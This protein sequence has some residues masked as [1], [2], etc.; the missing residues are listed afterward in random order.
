M[1]IAHGQELRKGRH[2]VPGHCY[3]L[4]SVTYNR[5]PV[6]LDFVSARLCIQA[7]QYQHNIGR[8]DSHAYVI[9]PDH[10]H[11]LVTLREKG[12]LSAIMQSVKGF[13]SRAIAK[14]Y[15]SRQECRSYVGAVSRPRINDPVWQK[16]YHDHALRDDE[17]LRQVARYIVANPVRAG[18]VRRAIEY[19]HWD[20]EWY[21]PHL[22]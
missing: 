18:L 5:Q 4:T 1:H 22:L 13:S 2:S 15:S 12:S 7:M 19:P 3:L 21:E 14:R 17:G 8:I 20:A 16:G 9:M 6:F 11:W 10:F